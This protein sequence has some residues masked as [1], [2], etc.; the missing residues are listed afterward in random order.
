MYK[1]EVILDIQIAG[2]QLKNPM[3]VAGWGVTEE[4]STYLS[5][6]LQEV[7]VP[8]VSSASCKK[9]LGEYQVTE[10]MLCAGGIPGQDACQVKFVLAKY[11]KD[12]EMTAYISERSRNSK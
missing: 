4:G 11:Y 7:S 10:N 6:I 5:T 2:M 12:S 1:I 9:S 3:T 8:V